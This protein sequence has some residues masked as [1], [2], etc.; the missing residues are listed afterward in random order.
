MVLHF[1]TDFLTMEKYENLGLV[2]EG[3]YG[4]VMKCRHKESN[5][6]VA[7]KKF[8]E[9]ED[10]KMVKKIAMREVRMLKQLR[11]ENLV[12]LIEV[13]RRKKRLFLVFEFVDHTV[14]DDLERYPNGLDE[15]RVRKIMWQVIRALEFCHNHNVIH[16][17]V[18]PENILVSKSGVVKVCDFGF[19]RTTGVAPGEVFTDY[20]ATRWYRGPELLVGDTKYGRPV[21]VWACGCLMI[22]M[23]TGEPL[24]P[25]DSD[26][27][28]LYH[29]IK[30]FGSLISRHKEI[31]SR[32]PLF[33]GMR[34]P[35]TK[36][37]EPLEKRIKVASLALDFSKQCLRLDPDSRPTCTSLLKHEY[38]TKD[39]FSERFATELKTR[40]NREIAE[41]PL[42]KPLENYDE[43][44]REKKKEKKMRKERETQERK[45]HRETRDT[46]E[47][48]STKEYKDTKEHKISRE[49]KEHKVILM[50]HID[51]REGKEHRES[52]DTSTREYK[53]DSKESTYSYKENKKGKGWSKDNVASDRVEKI[54][55]KYPLPIPSHAPSSSQGHG[56]QLPAMKSDGQTSTFNI[57]STYNVSTDMAGTITTATTTTTTSAATTSSPSTS[58][59]IHS[60]NQPIN[61]QL[62]PINEHRNATNHTIPNFG[63]RHSISNPL[64]MAKTNLSFSMNSQKSHEDEQANYGSY[65]SPTESRHKKHPKKSS[66]QSNQ[67]NTT[68]LSSEHDQMSPGVETTN[69]TRLSDSSRERRPSL[70]EASKRQSRSREK[71]KIQEPSFLP[72][73]VGTEGKAHQKTKG[74]KKMSLAMPHITNLTPFQGSS[75]PNQGTLNGEDPNLP[76]V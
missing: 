75:M 52:K 4:M 74:Q 44:S 31:F 27:D 38:F 14:L 16:R 64:N 51:V 48:K 15:M 67:A 56:S 73:V 50:D 37:I 17:D 47:H 9:S 34:L 32:N 19:A 7:I 5:Q 63:S 18:K 69:S 55:R 45:E 23:L 20:V 26:I 6:I 46:R 57:W 49:N 62:T 1:I 58:V 39:N 21:D 72:D 54:N 53:T 2:G 65:R 30:C 33:A 10:D 35:E 41:N 13:F 70:G 68:V 43:R 60:P 42:L 76:S 28:Q 11:H 8:L 29:I 40:I 3:S 71:D 59:D 22:E 12:N 66:S 61:R 24:F 36:Q 25:G